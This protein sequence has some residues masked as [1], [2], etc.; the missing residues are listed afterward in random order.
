MDTQIENY[1]NLDSKLKRN[2][3]QIAMHSKFTISDESKYLE[4]G[5][6]LI[7]KREGYN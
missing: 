7:A 5:L 3:A 1:Y 4:L 2:K 6:K